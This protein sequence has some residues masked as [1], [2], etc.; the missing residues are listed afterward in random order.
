MI[1][2]TGFVMGIVPPLNVGWCVER[3]FNHYRPTFLPMKV[4]RVLDASRPL[5]QRG[6]A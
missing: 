3:E 6:V 4:E 5:E 2:P 1:D